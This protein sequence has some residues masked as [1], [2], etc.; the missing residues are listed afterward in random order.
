MNRRV[1]EL[2]RCKTEEVDTDDMVQ[3]ERAEFEYQ[4]RHRVFEQG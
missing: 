3:T 4:G 1:S 2:C